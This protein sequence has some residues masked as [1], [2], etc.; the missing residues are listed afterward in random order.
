MDMKAPRNIN[1]VQKLNGRITALGRFMSC[2]VKRSLSFFNALK[3]TQ[4]LEWNRDC[5]EAFKELKKFLTTPPLLSRPLKGETLY[6]Y[7]CA[8]KETIEAVMVR[9]E[10]GKLKPIYY[11]SRVLKGAETRYPKIEKMA[12][13]VVT[14]TKKLKYYFQSHNMVVRTNQPL[15]KAIQRPETS[16]RL[17]HWSIQLSEHD[18]QY[19]P[20]HTLKAQALADFIAEIPPGE[21]EELVPELLRELYVDGASNEKGVGAGAILKGP[22]KIY[23]D[24]QLVVN[25]L[26]GEYQAK[27]TG[28]IEYLEKVT[29][30][31]RRLEA[32]GG[33]WEI[34]QFSREVKIDVDAIAKSA[35]EQGDLFMKM[36]LKETLESPSIKEE[37][38]MTI[39]EA[40]SWMT[41][42]IKYLDQGELPTNN[43]EAIRTIRKFAKY[44]Y[45][46]RVLYRTSLTHPWARCVSHESGSLI[47]KEIHE[48]IYGAHEGEVTIA[49][50]TML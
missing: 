34:I 44:S 32:Q 20:R 8:R 5:E 29:K 48:G 13:A 4:K 23:S 43:I 42:L 45:H 26:N 1:E 40:D 11:I 47:L 38:I 50:K 2:S 21:P 15:R 12:F 7:I 30:L 31:F 41:P 33:Q 37:E 9:E 17:V 14:T 3:G 18:I 24:S 46:N 22:R 36:Q 28:M 25:Q 6:L 35:S 27:E 19:E 49:R 16:G 39:D 10:D